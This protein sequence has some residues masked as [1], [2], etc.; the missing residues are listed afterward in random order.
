MKVMVMGAGGQG[1]PCA[2][3]LSRD[4]DVS[5]VKLCDINMELLE[6]VKQK[7]NS[8]KVAIEKVDASDI[9]EISAAAKGMDVIIDLVPPVFFMNVM[10]A[11]YLSGVHYVNTAW[12]EY[13]F[14]NFEEDDVTL[15]GKL[16]MYDEFADRNLTAILG[17]GMSCGYATNVMA[18]YYVDKLDTVES[19]KIRLAKKDTSY[20]DEEEILHPWNP[21]WNPRQALLDFIT[22]TYKFCDGDFIKMEE[23]FA[24]PEIWEFPAP[25]GKTLVSHHAHEEPLTIPQSFVKKGLKYCDFKYYVNKQ[26]AP[27]VALGLGQTDK[28][29][30]RGAEVSPI[31]VVLA[32][33]PESKNAFLDEDPSK[34]AKLDETKFVS[35]MLE[36]KGVKAGKEITYLVHVPNMNTP[37]QRLYDAYGTSLVAVALPAAVGA[38]MA[39]EG[40]EKGV[41]SPQDMDPVRFMELMAKGG[42]EHR[43]EETIL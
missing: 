32:F 31:D 19:I 15:G 22:P 13:L 36:I 10:K 7:I 27:I 18:R 24:E 9:G 41:I 14:E 4:A 34:F 5:E 25:I 43:W 33:V 12:E 17:C 42:F 16:K 40:T 28:I 3:I 30:V 39:V 29:S 2:S 23:I 1:A 8:A 38:K 11:A 6:K 35:I 37:R 20:S 26:I 21:G